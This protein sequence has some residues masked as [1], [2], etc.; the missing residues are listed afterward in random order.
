MWESVDVL[1]TIR[2]QSDSPV[3]FGRGSITVSSAL[4]AASA[5][6]LKKKEYEFGLEW[7]LPLVDA[8]PRSTD[9]FREVRKLLLEPRRQFTGAE[10]L[11]RD[12][13]IDGDDLSFL[14]APAI[15]ARCATR[16]TLEDWRRVGTID[17]AVDRLMAP[18]GAFT[19]FGPPR[20]S[21]P[22]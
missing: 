20:R 10:Q 14:F 8:R 4:V 17:Q 1:L 7:D 5:E 2:N 22:S 6:A 21:R 12:L 9:T 11:V 3:V 13:R 18:L 19:F 15:E 16:P